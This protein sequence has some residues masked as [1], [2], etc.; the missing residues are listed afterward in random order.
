[1][2]CGAFYLTGRFLNCLEA[3]GY[4]GDILKSACN[5]FLCDTVSSIFKVGVGGISGS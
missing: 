4:T 5:H 2:V 1:M 3:V